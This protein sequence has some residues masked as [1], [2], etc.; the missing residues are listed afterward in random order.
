MRIG[1]IATLAG[2]QVGTLRFYERE[3]LLPP[4]RRQRSGYRAFDPSTVVRVR[5]IRRAQELGFSLVEIREL[6]AASDARG[7][8]VGAELE[9]LAAEKLAEIDARIRDLR[10]V[11]RAV[12]KVTED[13]RCEAPLDGPCPILAALGGKAPTR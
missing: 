12:L 13:L 5:F 7:Q 1:E 9:K 8:V 2:V 11:R 10:R 3:R 4:A 6:L